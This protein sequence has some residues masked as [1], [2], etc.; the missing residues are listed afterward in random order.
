MHEIKNSVELIAEI[1]QKEYNHLKALENTDNC[2][3]FSI[4]YR[5]GLFDFFF[6]LIL[7]GRYIASY[8]G[9]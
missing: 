7:K 1:K 9:R 2:A 8:A 5:M 4:V 6:F 3:A